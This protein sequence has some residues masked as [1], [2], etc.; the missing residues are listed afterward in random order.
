MYLC[1][2]KV[3]PDMPTSGGIGI[4]IQTSTNLDSMCTRRYFG[5][6]HWNTV[7][8]SWQEMPRPT[9]KQTGK[10]T[11]DSC[12]ILK[13]E[14]GRMKSSIY[15]VYIQNSSIHVFRQDWLRP[16]GRELSTACAV[17]IRSRNDTTPAGRAVRVNTAKR[18]LFCRDSVFLIP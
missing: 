12:Y 5:N 2:Y 13:D 16:T 18:G 10:N 14:P 11:A 9:Y 17:P 1:M 8:P 7:V 3:P 6:R 15:F 4:K